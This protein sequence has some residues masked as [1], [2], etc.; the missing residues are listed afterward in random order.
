MPIT[1]LVFHSVSQIKFF[2]FEL[3]TIIIFFKYFL[4]Y[5][6]FS[7]IGTFEHETGLFIQKKNDVY[8]VIYFN[9]NYGER[10]RNFEELMSSLGTNKTI[11]GYVDENNNIN[12]QCSY[13]VWSD[14]IALMMKNQ[15]PFNR[16]DLLPFSTKYHYCVKK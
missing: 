15:N 14:L 6:S 3:K 16:K 2:N 13:L 5:F 9:P 11:R 12:S 7:I 4:I 10:L 1:R 8:D